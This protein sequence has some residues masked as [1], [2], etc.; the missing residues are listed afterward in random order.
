MTITI[1]LV[2]AFV[3]EAQ[4]P[5][6]RGWSVS[7]QNKSL[8]GNSD[9]KSPS[10]TKAGPGTGFGVNPKTNMLQ[11]KKALLGK[12]LEDPCPKSQRL[13]KQQAMTDAAA[14]KKKTPWGTWG[15]FMHKYR[16]QY[17]ACS[18]FI[19]RAYVEAARNVLEPK[20]RAMFAR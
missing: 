18:A 16:Q 12:A 8:W 15:T 14:F 13:A 20:K 11:K 1:F 9:E 7:P 2:T 6:M 19:K 10:D 17:G 5:V 4:V 3:C